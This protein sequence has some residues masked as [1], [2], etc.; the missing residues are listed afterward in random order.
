MKNYTKPILTEEKIILEDIC[1]VSQADSGA[2]STI[3]VT[4]LFM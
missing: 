4:D 1:T 3:T 2:G